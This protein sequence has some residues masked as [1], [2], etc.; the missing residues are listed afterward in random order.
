MPHRLPRSARHALT[1]VKVTLVGSIA[2]AGWTAQT[3]AD[4]RPGGYADHPVDDQPSRVVKVLAEHDCSVTGFD[5][6]QPLSA[7]VR[8]AQ[9]RLRFVSFDTGWRVFVHDGGA[10]LVAVCLDEAPVR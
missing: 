8:S 6:A 10:Q 3:V 2:A 7:V 1:A 9:G 5:D 4:A